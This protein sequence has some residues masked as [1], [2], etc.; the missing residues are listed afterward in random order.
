[1]PKT[2]RFWCQKKIFFEREAQS[3][4]FPRF[5]NVWFTLFEF[6]VTND[7]FLFAITV[8]ASIQPITSRS[9]HYV[10]LPSEK[11]YGFHSSL[12]TS[13]LATKIHEQELAIPLLW[14]SRAIL[15][16][17]KIVIYYILVLF[18]LNHQHLRRKQT[19]FVD[20]SFHLWTWK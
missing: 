9:Y 6:L 7:S 18:F 13:M 11:K 1:M 10:P 14:L 12:L 2:I 20:S 19:L 15:K 4:S 3:K 17:P 8:L 16:N 5:K